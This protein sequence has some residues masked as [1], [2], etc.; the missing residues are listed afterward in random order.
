MSEQRA[1]EGSKPKLWKWV[2][3]PLIILLAAVLLLNLL[4]FGWRHIAYSRYDGGMTRT[5][6]SSALF[7]SY[8]AKDEDGFDY[9]VKYPDYLSV[10]GNLAVGFPGLL[11]CYF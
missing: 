11:C 4:W 3:I 7:P 6:M 10:T 9:S 8:A 1:N 2:R 5:E